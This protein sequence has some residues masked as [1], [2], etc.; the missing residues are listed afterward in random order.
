MVDDTVTLIKDYLERYEGRTDLTESKRD[1]ISF[2]VHFDDGR[3]EDT[4]MKMS[5]QVTFMELRKRVA[6]HFGIQPYEITFIFSE[7]AKVQ[8]MSDNYALIN[9]P[10]TAYQI[11]DKTCYVRSLSFD[12][13]KSRVPHYILS[14]H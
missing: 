5:K 13:M 12:V 1:E 10:L 7:K 11:E 3:F 2:T 6:D 14:N 8:E 4:K 9:K